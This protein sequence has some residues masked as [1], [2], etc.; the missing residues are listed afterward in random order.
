MQIA[1][2]RLGAIGDTLLTVPA[3]HALGRA[4]PG[5]RIGLVGR[6][7]VAHLLQRCGVIAHSE[8]SES[9]LGAWLLGGAGSAR[10]AAHQ[11][12]LA[13]PSVAV[14]WRRTAADDVAARWA[15]LGAGRTL[16][17]PSHPPEG[18]RQHIADHLVATL[19]PLGVLPPREAPRLH[20]PP[21]DRAVGRHLLAALGV[22]EPVFALHPGS[23]GAAKCWPPERFAALGRTL[24]QH[25][26]IVLISG[27][28]DRDVVR[29]VQQA[30]GRTWPVAAH[31]P[32]TDV[33]QLLAHVRA[34]VGN[35]S[36]PSHLA[37]L[38]G[39]PTVALYGPTDPA[40]WGVRGPRVHLVLPPRATLATWSPA[41]MDAIT[42]STVLDALRSLGVL[43]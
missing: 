36:G 26:T 29:A 42:V 2:L 9:A 30:A 27:P 39:C 10:A 19:A 20:L 31:L 34:Y 8:D 32:L 7:D 40:V 11:S 18:A 1:V 21:Q 13:A 25:G 12:V 14:I 15:A 4:F 43:A 23:G 35:D 24:E 3:L 41:P 17:A 33:A 28:A 5:A 16:L 6:R 22:H 37:A 38:L